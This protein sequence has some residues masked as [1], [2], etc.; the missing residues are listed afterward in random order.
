MSVCSVPEPSEQQHCRHC[1]DPIPAG[2]RRPR[3]YCSDACRQADYRKRRQEAAGGSEPA[4][5]VSG[6]PVD[7]IAPTAESAKNGEKFP[8]DFKG[9]LLR[10]SNPRSPLDL[11]GRGRRWPGAEAASGGAARGIG[12]QSR[13][14]ALIASIPADLSIPDFL[15]RTAS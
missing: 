6:H 4:N 15:R 13:G 11:F 3:E 10:N 7:L 9:R 2:D 14:A 8:N 12:D 1:G 5:H